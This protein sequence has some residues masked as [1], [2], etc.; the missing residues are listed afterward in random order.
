MSF[1]LCRR[2]ERSITTLAQWLVCQ[3][4]TNRIAVL[5]LNS[6]GVRGF[7]DPNVQVN[8]DGTTAFSQ[9]VTANMSKKAEHL[10]P[11]YLN[12]LGG[13]WLEAT[14]CMVAGSNAWVA[15]HE[16]YNGGLNNKW[17]TWSVT[18]LSRAQKTAC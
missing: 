17:A 9:L 10:T 15:T 4:S 2:T 13:D 14:Q 6:I 11:W 1:C 5:T 3:F 16:A 18:I 12:Y 8:P 7:A